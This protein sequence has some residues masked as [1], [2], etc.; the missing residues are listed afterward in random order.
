MTD[1]YR[2]PFNYSRTSLN[3]VKTLAER[4]NLVLFNEN[5]RVGYVDPDT[6]QVKYLSQNADEVSYDN[7][8][9]DG[10][11]TGVSANLQA[12]A[13][14]I[15]ELSTSDIPIGDYDGNLNGSSTL[16]EALEALDGLTGSGISAPGS[17][18]NLIYN[19]GGSFGAS[20]EVNWDGNE[21]AVQGDINGVKGIFSGDVTSS[22]KISASSLGVSSATVSLANIG[23]LFATGRTTG[24]AISVKVNQ[25]S[26]GVSLGNA[27]YFDGLKFLRANSGNIATVGTGVVSYVEDVDNFEVT[28]QGVVSGY[29]G[30][31]VGGWYYVSDSTDGELS[32]T[33]GATIVNPVGLAITS[34]SLMVFPLRAD[35]VTPSVDGLTSR[36]EFDSSNS[37]YLYTG[38]AARGTA[39]SAA[40]WRI[41]RF[42]FGTGAV[43]FADGDQLYDNVFDNRE[44]LSYS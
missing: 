14:Y 31:S 35:L 1:V 36:S 16:E 5:G 15:D 17:D 41:S 34:E 8:Y 10:N 42:D 24:L 22:G 11:L 4:G 23:D 6:K 3:E 20:S 29:T 38:R 18:G 30:L 28:Y 9:F 7:K 43:T 19:S 2:V 13:K 33:Q 12:L 39:T 44:S 25:V 37:A 27:T 21:F 26:H 40:S 32:L